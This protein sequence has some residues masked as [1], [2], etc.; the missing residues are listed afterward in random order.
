MWLIRAVIRIPIQFFSGIIADKF[1][2]K[3][4]SITIYWIS[5]VLSLLFVFT[6]SSYIVFAFVLIFLLQGTSDM[7][8]TAQAAM[9]PEI[10]EKKDLE[11]A[12]SVFSVMGTIILLTAPGIGGILYIHFGS[13]VLFVIDSLTFIIAAILF[14]RINY[15]SVKAEQASPKKFMLFAF[16]KEGYT[17]IKEN[18][19][20]LVFISV[21]MCYAI[22]GRFYEIY[23]VYVADHII[24]VGAE[25]IV[26]FS[27]AMAIGSLLGP[28]WIR[29]IKRKG[30][31]KYNSFLWISLFASMSYILWGNAD[32]IVLSYAANMAMGFLDCNMSILCNS[33]I[34]EKVDHQYIGRVMSFYKIAI[35]CSAILGIVLAPVLLELWSI[36]VAM[37][38]AGSISIVFIV[39]LMRVKSK[40]SPAS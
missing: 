25:G 3:K 12:N 1:N 19:M 14:T 38:A 17:Q 11:S 24:K 8:N 36:G 22:L 9:L 15:N 21:M 27:Y 6:S 29:L 7:D 2:R 26:Y 37:L 13:D 20:I 33:I 30:L 35:V 16:A 39:M 32:M 4:I 23:K 40:G 5:A 10:V 18:R 28:L 34:Q 31:N